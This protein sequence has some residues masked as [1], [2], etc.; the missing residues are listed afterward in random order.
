[1]ALDNNSIMAIAED[2]FPFFQLC[3]LKIGECKKI[4]AFKFYH[5]MYV[6]WCLRFYVHFKIYLSFYNPVRCTI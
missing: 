5:N 6:L 3:L 1:M 4:N 2:N